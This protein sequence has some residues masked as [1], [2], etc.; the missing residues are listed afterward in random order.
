V[1]G[2]GLDIRDQIFL[3]VII[4]STHLKSSHTPG[5][6]MVRVNRPEREDDHLSPSVAKVC[7]LISVP[8]SKKRQVVSIIKIIWIMLFRDVIA[9]YS[10]NH[11][12]YPVL[13]NVKAYGTYSCHCDW[14]N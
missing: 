3:F 11:T 9:V 7:S 4:P 8:V 1:T 5:Q 13:L 6:W 14:K 2:N 10:E 12:K